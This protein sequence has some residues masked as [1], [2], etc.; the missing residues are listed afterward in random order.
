[1]Q[2]GSAPNKFGG[3]ENAIKSDINVTP[4][5]D[6]CLVLLIIFMVVVPMLATGIEVDLPHTANPE[7]MPEGERQLNI[8]IKHDGAV[9]VNAN[10]VPND[11]VKAKL[12]EIYSTPGGEL[13]QVVIKGDRRLKYREVR[14]LMQ[15]VNEAGF[16][17]VGLVAEKG[18]PQG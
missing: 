8:S 7:K 11:Q 17:G 6:V 13:K 10:W 12:L 2:L 3:S 14:S 1:V 15:Q 4:L 16:T 18:K 9:F 5:V